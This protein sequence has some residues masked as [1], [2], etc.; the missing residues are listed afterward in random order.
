M[1][2]V[3]FWIRLKNFLS[4]KFK[5]LKQLFLCLCSLA[6]LFL[7][8]C[9]ST[10]ELG[11][12][13][14]VKH[15]EPKRQLV[16]PVLR[17]KEKLRTAPWQF[18]NSEETYGIEELKDAE[19]QAKA[20]MF[21]LAIVSYRQAIIQSQ[22]NTIAE[23]ILLRLCGT[24]LKL[25][26]SKEVLEEIS[27][28]V[29]TRSIG[30]QDISADFALI[31][32]YAYVHREDEDQTFAWLS[33]VNQKTEGKG[34]YAASAKT[35]LKLYL[36]G[37]SLTESLLQRWSLDPFVS[38]LITEEQQ[39][40]TQGGKIESGIDRRWWTPDYYTNPS[41]LS[42]NKQEGTAQETD[43][44]LTA[45]TPTAVEETLVQTPQSQVVKI[46]ILLP[47]TGQYA[48]H[49]KQVF[50][51]I[52][53][54]F[55]LKGSSEKFD[56]IIGDTKGESYVAVKEYERLVREEN[57]V[58]VL[59]PLLA[60]TSEEVAKKSIE[61]GVPF[62][63]FTKQAGLMSLSPYVFRLGVTAES[64]V[65][66]ILRYAVELEGVKNFALIYPSGLNSKEYVDSANR[67]SANYG[68][69]ITVNASY[70]I[71]DMA[72]INN[73]VSQIRSANVQAV[74]FTES[75]ERS[76]S[77]LEQIRSNCDKNIRIFGNAQWNDLASLRTYGYLI[78]GAA[79]VAPFYYRSEHAE[80]KS[81]IQLYKDRF[82]VE[83]ELLAAQSFDAANILLKVFDSTSDVSTKGV[84]E[85]LKNVNLP[86]AVTGKIESNS[87]RD[88]RRKMPVLRWL[89]GQI[90]EM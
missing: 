3:L 75:L 14:P 87:L 42:E 38:N 85:G 12:D 55:G 34:E 64:Q 1:M 5:V 17:T 78:E 21:D 27:K 36:K 23:A 16:K 70:V 11:K 51:G 71:G 50:Q 18:W 10:A 9:S 77:V 44:S 56:L 24:M 48:E 2:N 73:I 31:V 52:E 45:Q 46:G 49:A 65:D 53:L 60:K 25:G 59:G 4:N 6:V 82:G 41:D 7:L 43:L 58:A 33:L 76:F 20:G 68:A 83:P 61:F 57:V 81:F 8:S 19:Q 37:V 74:I 40:R 28:Y 66:T 39:R 29:R 47:I 30:F 67:L 69:N 72:S 54:A 88:F 35:L 86:D 79:F 13:K 90:V 63:S 84:L 26:R 22:S 89:S 62:I 15:I 80:I 32:S